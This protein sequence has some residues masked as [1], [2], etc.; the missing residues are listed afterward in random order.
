MCVANAPV[1][2][3]TPTPVPVKISCG[4]GFC[5]PNSGETITN[6][7]NDCKINTTP[8]VSTISVSFFAKQ[9]A[10]STQWQKAAQVGSNG[11]VLFMISLL[12]NSTTQIDN[13]N[14]SANIPS[15]ISSLGNL[16]INGVSVAGD[17]ITGIN[18]GSIAPST[19]KLVNFE[20]KTQT[21]ST[22]SAKQAIASSNGQTDNVSLDFS[23]SQPVAAVVAAVVAAPATTGF[24]G[25]LKRWYIWILAGLVLVLLFV[26]VFRRLSSTV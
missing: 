7:P 17:I 12:N 14:V 9:D 19:T 3:P 16:Q 10:S 1:V 22:A 26:V 11:Q 20:G 8:A 21:I 25:F 15:E 18:V 24:L 5:E 4:N 6:C 13:V 23:P 2:T